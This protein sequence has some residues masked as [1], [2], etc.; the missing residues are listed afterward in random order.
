MTEDAYGRWKGFA[1][2]MA[3]RFPGLR[4]ANRRR[5]EALVREYFAQIEGEDGWYRRT[6]GRG[7][8]D[9]IRDWDDADDRGL[10]TAVLYGPGDRAQALLEDENP[11][12][13]RGTDARWDRWHEAW[14]RPFKCCVRAGLDLAAASSPGVV[15]FTVGDLRV[16]YRPRKVPRW[17]FRGMKDPGGDPVDLNSP[18]VDDREAVWL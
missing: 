3:R 17:V 4:P 14:G 13:G 8:V 11:C 15:G 1:V 18:A 16:I 2:R 6:T 9:R 7:L 5:I 10:G 12:R